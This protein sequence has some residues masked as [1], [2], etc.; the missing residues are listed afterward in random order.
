MSSTSEAVP[1][2]PQSEP[3]KTGS[4]VRRHPVIFIL[5]GIGGLLI[6]AFVALSVIGLAI[7]FGIRRS[8]GESVLSPIT[9]S[10]CR[11]SSLSQD[12][13]Q[14]TLTR[15]IAQ[16]GTVTVDGVYDGPQ[17]NT[18]VARMMVS[19]FLFRVPNRERNYSGAGTATF[20]RYNDGRWML[21][22]VDL[23]GLSGGWIT[24]INMEVQ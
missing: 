7:S 3:V 16:N 18:A 23:S 2:N 17:Q 14:R 15:W 13:A 19:D 11:G 8:S 9:N 1:Q 20:I 21:S 12:C 4:I 5:G 10:S 22:R 24:D 6:L